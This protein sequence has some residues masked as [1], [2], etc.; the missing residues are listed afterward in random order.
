MKL[1]QRR[2]ARAYVCYHEDDKD[3]PAGGPGVYTSLE[4][5]LS[6][7]AT[8]AAVVERAL[9]EYSALR[10][11]YNLLTEL[12]AIHEQIDREILAHAK[13]K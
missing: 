9:Q 13:N 2:P 3:K 6:E 12:A 7:P 4:H 5:A 11:K 1:L 8:R 10:R